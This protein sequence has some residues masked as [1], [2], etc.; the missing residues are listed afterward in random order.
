[1]TSKPHHV[2]NKEVIENIPEPIKTGKEILPPPSKQ[3]DLPLSE[4]KSKQDKFEIDFLQPWGAIQGVSFKL[5]QDYKFPLK[6]GFLL[7]DKSIAFQNKSQVPGEIVFGHQDSEKKISKRFVFHNSNYTIELYIKIE[8]LKN[9]ALTINLPLLLGSLDLSSRNIQARYQDIIV[10]TQDKVQHLQ[11]RKDIA[12]EDIKFL[13]LRDRYF[14]LIVEPEGGKF[15]GFIH[16]IGAEE[17]EIGLK[18]K[19]VILSAGEQIEQKF[20]IYMG[21]QD[22]RL[23][24]QINPSWAGIIN[25]GMFDFIAQILWQLLEFLYRLLHNWGWAIVALSFLVYFALY[26]LSLKQMR[27]MKEMQLLQ[28]KIE[29]LRKVYKDNPQKLNKEVLELY[30]QHKVNPLGGCLPLILQMPIFFALYQ[31]LLRAVALKGANFLWIKDLS[32]PD[33][34]FILPVSLPL[35]GNEINIL[36]IVMTVIMF[37]QQKITTLSTAGSSAEQQKLM[38]IIFP[39]MFGFIFYRMPSGLVLYWFINSALMLS[40]YI[41]IHRRD[42]RKK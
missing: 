6:Y 40:Y 22:L 34:L 12:F 27:S 3:E 2:E 20:L 36:P 5:H 29:E 7:G 30:R 37:I 17:S 13:G 1:M 21:P 8:N 28:P 39:L 26:P 23:I 33:R 4:F 16:K 19:D 38:M 14:A 25:Y 18:F 31:V 35:L 24:N 15:S 11:A 32:E 41:L 10:A 9:D 42:D